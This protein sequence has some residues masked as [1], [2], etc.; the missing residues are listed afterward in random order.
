MSETSNRSAEHLPHPSQ[1]AW[2]AELKSMLNSGA[3]DLPTKL[4][5]ELT[6]TVQA[7]LEGN[8]STRFHVILKAYGGDR[9]TPNGAMNDQSERARRK[10]RVNAAVELF[11]KDVIRQRPQV[12]LEIVSY[13]ENEDTSPNSAP[14]VSLTKEI[15]D[16]WPNL[17]SKFQNANLSDDE[18]KG[19]ASDERW[20]KICNEIEFLGKK[21]DHKEGAQAKKFSFVGISVPLFFDQCEQVGDH[22]ESESG[23]TPQTPLVPFIESIIKKLAQNEGASTTHEQ[24]H[25]AVTRLTAGKHKVAFDNLCMA[26]FGTVLESGRKEAKLPIQSGLSEGAKK[27][28]GM[29]FSNNGIEA[30]GYYSEIRT[31]SKPDLFSASEF[32]SQFDLLTAKRSMFAEVLSALS[33]ET[34][35]KEF[36]SLLFRPLEKST[37][38]TEKWGYSSMDKH[39]TDGSI[40]SA[41]AVEERL[42]DRAHEKKQWILPLDELLESVDELISLLY[43]LS[44]ECP[45][46]TI[47]SEM[48]ALAIKVKESSLFSQ[49]KE[50][51]K[52]HPELRSGDTLANLIQVAKGSNDIKIL[53]VGTDILALCKEKVEDYQ[54]LK[55][56]WARCG[57][58]SSFAQHQ[59][60]MEKIHLIDTKKVDFTGEGIEVID[61]VNPSKATEA[62]HYYSPLRDII[63]ARA[64]GAKLNPDTEL[65][66]RVRM[67]TPIT[68]RLDKTKPIMLITGN[69]GGGKTQ[70]MQTLA[71]TVV[72]ALATGTNQTA[73]VV[74]LA[75]S[76]HDM[77]TLINTFTHSDDHS[78]YQNESLKLKGAL[79]VLVAKDSAQAGVLIMDEIGKGT[80]SRDA[81]ALTLAVAAY[82]KHHNIF[83]VLASH[84]GEELLEAASVIGL[85]DSIKICAPDPD[86]HEIHELS[87][88]AQSRGIEVMRQRA[89]GQIPPPILSRLC[90]NATRI[91]T[92]VAQGSPIDIQS[93]GEYETR[94]FKEGDMPYV[95]PKALRDVGLGDNTTDSSINYLSS[96]GR[97]YDQHTVRA[98]FEVRCREKD[99]PRGMIARS[100]SEAIIE[101]ANTVGLHETL[102]H[103][104]TVAD[105][106]TTETLDD[107]AVQSQREMLLEH[108]FNR[109]MDITLRNKLKTFDRTSSSNM[110]N[111]IAALKVSVETLSSAK[112]LEMARIVEYGRTILK[113]EDL[114]KRAQEQA[115][116]Q[117]EDDFIKILSNIA[118]IHI[119]SGTYTK[120]KR[121]DDTLSLDIDKLKAELKSGNRPIL[122][123]ILA[124]LLKSKSASNWND[125]YHSLHERL[126]VSDLSKWLDSNNQDNLDDK[127]KKGDFTWLRSIFTGEEQS[128]RYN[129]LA[130]LAKNMYLLAQEKWADKLPDS[131]TENIYEILGIEPNVSIE[132]I[133]NRLDSHPDKSTKKKFSK[134]F[135]DEDS[136]RLYDLGQA[137]RYGREAAFDLTMLNAVKLLGFVKS[138][139]SESRK[140]EIKDS[141]ALSLL[142]NYKR[143][144]SIIPQSLMVDDST[145]AI[146]L[147][148]QNGGGK[149]QFL[150]Q[151]AAN[152]IWANAIGYVPAQE[153]SIPNFDFVHCMVNSGQSEKNKSS[154]QNEIDRI[155]KLIEL[156]FDSGSPKNGIIF[157]D[158]PLA[159]TSS[160]D[161]IGIW[162]SLMHFFKQQ[163]VKMVFTNHNHKLYPYMQSAGIRSQILAFG[164]T[165]G[166]NQFTPTRTALE[167]VGEIKSN[168]ISAAK[169]MGIAQ[170]IVEVAEYVRTV[171]SGAA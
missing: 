134:I 94:N 39:K 62:I 84:Y 46:N 113:L 3:I 103:I 100:H 25:Q 163:G 19:V 63:Q 112:H 16:T 129:D 26:N 131:S 90:E 79:E 171:M 20:T 82:C 150:V 117:A 52:N 45:Q 47:F 167:N 110:M 2:D 143:K 122:G 67:E 161:Q 7:R 102:D 162:V 58:L 152:C 105:M 33:H 53:K 77:R 127:L 61:A 48:H 130:I 119:D 115:F 15:N 136:R 42:M 139:K 35:A 158:E 75:P 135:Q 31:R 32:Q 24:E 128:Y 74:R 160:P 14:C 106:V 93:L 125:P 6:T 5:S 73:R 40:F 69:N 88:P 164:D 109:E 54:M 97:S 120:L 80:D 142:A 96:L 22:D 155:I 83:L 118:I 104:Y 64:D 78:A 34:R 49:L 38:L 98:Q 138:K 149:T 169:N 116:A 36:A 95:T 66:I 101:N 56:L 166:P 87:T 65:R 21:R 28:T 148:G 133:R 146:V 157:V 30:E 29:C 17:L 91:R 8:A 86:T 27:E 41:K 4:F 121:D 159:G 123:K 141:I 10:E 165:E 107:K 111:A 76:L 72:H 51:L 140:M 92:A 132:I 126:K 114:V 151:M 57:V 124:L 108:G 43:D 170:N 81:V 137:I 23:E 13:L 85:A 59:L 70:A 71:E 153:A 168:G 37:L 147:G 99:K 60:R 89:S 156:Y 18:I 144:D 11:T 1:K 50:A 44:Q 12:I 154:F 55:S 145:D 9:Y 68:L